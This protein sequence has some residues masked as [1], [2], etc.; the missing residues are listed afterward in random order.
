MRE[1]NRLLSALLCSLQQVENKTVHAGRV[2]FQFSSFF[3]FFCVNINSG[4]CVRTVMPDFNRCKL[5]V[6][7]AHLLLLYHEMNPCFCDFFHEWAPSPVKPHSV[8]LLPLLTCQQHLSSVRTTPYELEEHC[9]SYNLFVWNSC[10]FSCT[11]RWSKVCIAYTVCK[12]VQSS[13]KQPLCP[14]GLSSVKVKFDLKNADDQR[15]VQ[16]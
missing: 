14:H 7:H 11:G 2:S 9:V 8:N 13:G 10:F 6:I 5:K 12:H 15:P 1:H 3:S 16:I 4:S